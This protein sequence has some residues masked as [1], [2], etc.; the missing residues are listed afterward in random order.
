MRNTARLLKSL[1]A[2]LPA[3]SR[4]FGVKEQLLFKRTTCM[5]AVFPK[6]RASISEGR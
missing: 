2:A 1:V 6:L 5:S 4:R 3:S